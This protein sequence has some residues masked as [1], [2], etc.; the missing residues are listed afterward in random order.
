[1]ALKEVGR[2]PFLLRAYFVNSSKIAIANL[3][4]L[5]MVALVSQLKFSH[6]SLIFS[7]SR[8]S[9]LKCGGVYKSLLSKRPFASN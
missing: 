6:S 3:F 2:V 1:M 8:S 9:H 4:R 5:S 7:R